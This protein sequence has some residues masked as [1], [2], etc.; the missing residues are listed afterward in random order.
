MH[1]RNI[2]YNE[3]PQS[4]GCFCPSAVENTEKIRKLKDF[5]FLSVCKEGESPRTLR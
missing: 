2:L 3:G 5:H 1:F 4:Y